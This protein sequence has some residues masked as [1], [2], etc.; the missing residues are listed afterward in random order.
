MA[1]AVAAI[2]S[3]VVAAYAP[4]AARARR[5]FTSQRAIRR[6]NRGSGAVMAGA[7]MTIVVN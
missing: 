4:A 3:I 5:L 2:A 6:M 7:A 1:L